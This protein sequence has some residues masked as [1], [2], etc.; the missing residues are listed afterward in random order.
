VGCPL[1][2][3]NGRRKITQAHVRVS[4]KA[5]QDMGMI[6]EKGPSTRF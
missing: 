2:D 5:E 6:R 3:S 1:C 4:G